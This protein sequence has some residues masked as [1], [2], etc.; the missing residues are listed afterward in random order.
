MGQLRPRR[1]PGCPLKVLENKKNRLCRRFFCFCRFARL[2][3]VCGSV[4]DGG[5]G[6]FRQFAGK[7]H[8]GFRKVATASQ[9]P[10]LAK[11]SHSLLIPLSGGRLRKVE[12]VCRAQFATA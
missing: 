12:N 8:L 5:R 7:D 10:A 11:A 2:K 1:F 9:H 6:G 4:C 3:R